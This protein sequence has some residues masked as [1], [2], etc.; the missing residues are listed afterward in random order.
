MIPGS[1]RCLETGTAT[2][3]SILACRI[4]RTEEPGGSQSMG[5]ESETTERLTLSFS[6]LLNQK[7]INEDFFPPEKRAYSIIYTF[8]KIRLKSY[9]CYFFFHPFKLHTLLK[10]SNKCL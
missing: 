7:V 4:P 1:G 2:H 9:N 3:S 5:S 8:N 6:E 10:I